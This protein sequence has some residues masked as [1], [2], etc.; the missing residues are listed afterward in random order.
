MYVYS[1]RSGQFN[2]DLDHLL[3]YLTVSVTRRCARRVVSYRSQ[4]KN[5]CARAVVIQIPPGE[6]DDLN[7]AHGTNGE[8]IFSETI[9]ADHDL[10]IEMGI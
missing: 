4:P 5:M 8:S 3:I 9:T 10:G 1:S 7:R 2:P 6:H